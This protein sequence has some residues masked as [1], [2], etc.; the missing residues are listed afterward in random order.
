MSSLAIIIPAKNEASTI[1]MVL[2]NIAAHAAEATVIV[3]DDNSTDGTLD[4][5]GKCKGVIA[6]HSAVSLGIGGAVQ[7]GVR[8]ALDKGIDMFLRMDG[9][10][11]HDAR[12]VR[13]LMTS[14]APRTLV[15]GSRAEASFVQCS[16]PVRY[17]GSAFFRMLFRIFTKDIISDPTS[18]FI[19]FDRDIAMQFAEYL[20]AEYPEIESCVLLLRAGYAV[21]TAD[22]T[23]RSRGGGRSS[24]TIF[25]SIV[26]MVSVTMAFVVSFFRENPYRR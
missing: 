14:A 10:G 13:Q 22:V 18:G 26:Y 6:L 24:I 21:K 1:G 23:M 19:C 7:L 8:F 20:P 9:D 11:Q 2:A 4:E 16:D 12:F 25:R 15:I 3:V 17:A 5:V